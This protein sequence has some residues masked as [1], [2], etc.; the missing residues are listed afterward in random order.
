MLSPNLG[1]QVC[2]L[3]VTGITLL[4][5]FPL[6]NLLRKKLKELSRVKTE[7]PRMPNNVFDA[8]D[9]GDV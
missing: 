6:F 7:Q 8:V 4:S 5:T 9:S 3:C 1:L 2:A